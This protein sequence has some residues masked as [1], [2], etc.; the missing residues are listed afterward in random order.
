MKCKHVWF[1]NGPG[2]GLACYHCYYCGVGI[3]EP[4]R[5]E[6]KK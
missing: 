4:D 6:I 5:E 2:T 3:L 1:P